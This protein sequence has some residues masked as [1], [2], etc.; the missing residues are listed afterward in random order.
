MPVVLSSKTDS[1]FLIVGSNSVLLT[2]LY[3]AFA[4][5]YLLAFSRSY[6]SNSVLDTV[7]LT[8]SSLTCSNSFLN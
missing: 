6:A 1:I 8:R 4:T 2:F 3:R 7:L 5:V